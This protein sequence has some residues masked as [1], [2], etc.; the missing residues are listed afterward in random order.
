MHVLGVTAG[1]GLALT[2]AVRMLVLLYAVTSG[3]S[4]Y[5]EH[6]KLI[7]GKPE[8]AV[9]H[10]VGITVHIHLNTVPCTQILLNAVFLTIVCH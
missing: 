3:A 8:E 6:E 9:A 10:L 7:A 5:I 2:G 4:L 1:S